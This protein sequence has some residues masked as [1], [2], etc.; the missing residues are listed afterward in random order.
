MTVNGSEILRKMVVSFEAQTP[1]NQAKITVL[2][3]TCK[4]KLL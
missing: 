3:R 4:K 2:Q 1:T